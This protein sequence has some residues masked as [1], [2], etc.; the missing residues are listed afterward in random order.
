MQALTIE[1]SKSSDT[2]DIDSRTPASFF[3]AAAHHLPDHDLL[4]VLKHLLQSWMRHLFRFDGPFSSNTRR[5]TSGSGATAFHSIREVL[6]AV[7]C[8]VLSDVQQI[9]GNAEGRGRPIS[10]E[11]LPN[12]ERCQPKIMLWHPCL[13]DE[14]RCYLGH[15][16][17]G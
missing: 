5:S 1:Q 17:S 11:S 15:L 13:N 6:K 12:F 16:V 7:A 2:S 8:T 10:T 3:Q 9:E 4:R 14:A